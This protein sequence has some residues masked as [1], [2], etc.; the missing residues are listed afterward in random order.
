MATGKGIVTEEDVKQAVS[1]RLRIHR[2]T[3][4]DDGAKNPYT[5]ILTTLKSGVYHLLHTGQ[6]HMEVLTKFLASGCC[7]CL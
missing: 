7:H 2:N 6:V 3:S 5:L 4:L 1:D